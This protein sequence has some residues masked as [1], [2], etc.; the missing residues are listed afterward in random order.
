MNLIALLL[1]LVVERMATKF[2][3][4]RRLRWLDRLIDAG[5]GCAEQLSA[6]PPLLPIVLLTLLLIFPVAAIALLL[7]DTLSGF[8]YM[9]FAI[10]VL[11][12]SFGP[13]DIGED[14]DEYCQALESG[15]PERIE[16]TAKA[17]VEGEVPADALQRI[18]TVEEAV[19]V[20]ANNRLFAVI[21]WF[22]VMGPVGPLGAWSYRVTD[23]VRRR[24]VYSAMREQ[25][26]DGDST[27]AM[28][29]DAA[30][31]LHG[32]LA[33]VPARLT[34]IGYAAAGH[35]EAAIGAWRALD[36]QTDVSLPEHNEHLLARVGVAAMALA[37]DDDETLEQRGVRGATAASRLVFRLLLMWAVVIGT[38]TLYGWT[39]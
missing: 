5:V 31:L 37:D 6:W 15:D 10:V 20:Q 39:Q 19:C 34:A 29:R 33:W 4:L 36:E 17:I 27:V 7:G 35:F 24:A 14:V 2:F 38:M 22:V 28:I 12:F 30:I 26:L 25:P 21:F 8:P 3:H 18:R 16:Q 9:A 23:L 32:W 13:K 1:G 11:F